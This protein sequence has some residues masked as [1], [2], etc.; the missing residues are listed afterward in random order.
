M[1]ADP[2]AT[3]SPTLAL[4]LRIDS[5]LPLAAA[6]MAAI[7]RL[8]VEIVGEERGERFAL[9]CTEAVNKAIR[10]PR[11]GEG[12]QAIAISLSVTDR[13]VVA[14]I[15]DQGSGM[16]LAERLAALPLNPYEN[17]GEF[18]EAGSGLW[19]LRQGADSVDYRRGPSGNELVLTLDLGAA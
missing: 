11:N 4:T 2:M 3:T 10:H 6:A 12:R 19:L 16:V 14:R 15:A 17:G 1:A 8:M 18:L 13:S 5:S 9:A 7:G